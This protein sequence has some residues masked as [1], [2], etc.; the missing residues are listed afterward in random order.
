MLASGGLWLSPVQSAATSRDE[1]YS[2]YLKAISQKADGLLTTLADEDNNLQ[3]WQNYSLITTASGDVITGI[4]GLLL[5]LAPSVEE[6][7]KI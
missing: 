6:D 1:T 3:Q 5:G 7:S 2:A 4:S